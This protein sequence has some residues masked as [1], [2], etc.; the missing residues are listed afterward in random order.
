MR[1][2]VFWREEAVNILVELIGSFLVSIALYNFAVNA[3][4]PMTGFSGIALILYRL[5][6]LPIGTVTIVLNIPVALLCYRLLGRGF[7][8]RS[9]RCM[10]ISS[11]MVDYIAPLLPVYNGDRLLAA[12]CTGV[13]GGFGYAMIYMRGSS[14]GGSDFIIMGV[15]AVRPHLSLGKIVL[16][17][18]GLIVLA[19]GVLFQDMDGIIYG[20]L[21][22]YIY[23]L[24]VDK[25]MYGLNAGKLAI[26]ITGQGAVVTQA[27]EKAC[28]RGAT[29]LDARGGYRQD[30][31]EVVLCACSNKQMY[32]V[33]KAVKQV[34]PAAFI[35][36][37][38]SNEVLGEGFILR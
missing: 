10:L 6:G 16:V 8:I 14:T 11:L 5:F 15:K 20:C 9:I 19:G 28:G 25:L 3:A 26:I 23:S 24:V 4:F 38:E 18:D 37:L 17:S 31:K 27:I 33:E 1:N 30:K 36:I 29:L 34:E 12:V 2:K 35:I 21:I 7:F 13:L 22:A 32:A